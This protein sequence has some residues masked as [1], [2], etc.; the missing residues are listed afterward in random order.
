MSRFCPSVTRPGAFRTPPP[1]SRARRAPPRAP[2][3]PDP[4]AKWQAAANKQKGYNPK[5]GYH[6]PI[7]PPP[8]PM[9]S[10]PVPDTRP[11]LDSITMNQRITK[12]YADMYRS[13]PGTFK[14]AG[15]ATLA[16][17]E[18][19][20]GEMQ[21]YGLGA[22][23]TNFYLN[24]T[25]MEDLLAKG[26]FAVYNDIYWQLLAYR[27]CGL[28][29]M[30]HA[31][32]VGDINNETYKA[33]QQIDEGKR[34]GNQASV[35]AGNEGLLRYEQGVAFQKSIY[36]TDPTLW[37]RASTAPISWVQILSSPSPVIRRR[38]TSS[39]RTTAS[40]TPALATS[41]SAGHQFTTVC[42]RP[43]RSW[44]ATGR[45]PRGPSPMRQTG[46]D[47]G[48]VWVAALFVGT[49][50]MRSAGPPGQK[51]DPSPVEIWM[52]GP[53]SHV[54]GTPGRATAKAGRAIWTPSKVSCALT[55]P[56]ARRARVQD[57]RPGR[58]DAAERRDRHTGL[59]AAAAGRGR[60][61]GGRRRGGAY[62]RADWPDGARGTRPARPGLAD[63][64]PHHRRLCA[65]RQ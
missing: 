39:A 32:D 54:R 61:P 22:S 18:V 49:F 46:L 16:S 2:I 48:A 59:A 34:T 41:G 47:R 27:S 13:D 38:S 17:R 28:D 20:G 11:G 37:S 51:H 53:V 56:P 12:A 36:D 19:G 5:D 24:A 60:I 29:E 58:D 57:P 45:P 6:I 3:Q 14:W 8:G 4:K 50:L 1:P 26:N 55:L 9:G 35:W 65:L 42:S 7:L 23:P 52:L 64:P 30:K 10:V 25:Q 21:A 63:P 40:P 15:M 62:R 33:W 31:R 44:T 43:G